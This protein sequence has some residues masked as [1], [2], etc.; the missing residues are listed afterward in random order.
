MLPTSQL[1]DFLFKRWCLITITV[2]CLN[3]CS[4]LKRLTVANRGSWSRVQISV[5]R[6]GTSTKILRSFPHSVQSTAHILFYISPPSLPFRHFP[7]NYS[8]PCYNMTPCIIFTIKTRLPFSKPKIINT[9]YSSKPLKLKRTVIKNLT[10]ICKR[11][12]QLLKFH[13]CFRL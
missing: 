7:F 4:V 6:P 11:Y 10:K 1:S 12:I 8:S 13:F 5:L 2:V 9:H 3:E